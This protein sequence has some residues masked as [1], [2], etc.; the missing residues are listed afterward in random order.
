MGISGKG[1][2]ENLTV[3]ILEQDLA[4]D[5]ARADEGRVERVDLVRGHDDFDVASI[6][7]PIQLVEQLQHRALD[8]A[9][10]PRSALV[11]LRADGIDL[12]DEHDGGRVLRRDLEELPHQP[13][14]ITQ[15]LLDEL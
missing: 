1:V 14:T 12:V 2:L 15:V 5:T 8:L 13:G 9:L 10:T 4:V 7:E 11:P 3:R 6:V